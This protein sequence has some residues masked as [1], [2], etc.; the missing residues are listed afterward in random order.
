M[1]SLLANLFSWSLSTSAMASILA[2]FIFVAKWLLKDRINPRWTY[3]LWM[4]L[5][6]RLLLPWTPE[7][8]F[9]VFNIIHLEKHQSFKASNQTVLGNE[10]TSAPNIDQYTEMTTSTLPP[11]IVVHTIGSSPTRDKP[12][13]LMLIASG[14]W[15][16]GAVLMLSFIIVANLRFNFKIRKEQII[17]DK[18]VRSILNECLVKMKIHRHVAL[19]ESSHVSC[20]TLVGLITPKLLLPR[21]TIT[22]LNVSQLR[23][24]FLHELSHIKRY[25]I[26]MNWMMNILL[27]LHWFNP[28]IL[29]AYHKMREDQEMACDSLALTHIHPSE[30]KDYAL[31]IIKLLEAYSSPIRLANAA[32]FSGNKDELKRRI[33]MITSFKR[34][35]KWSLIGPI[36]VL[37]LGICS[38]TSAKTNTIPNENNLSEPVFT[39][40]HL[41]ENVTQNGQA[42]TGHPIENVKPFAGINKG[43]NKA[44]LVVE[45]DYLSQIKKMNNKGEYMNEVAIILN[46][47]AMSHQKIKADRMGFSIKMTPEFLDLIIENIEKAPYIEDRDNY[48][49]I[50]KNWKAGNFSRV[51]DDHDYLN[52]RQGGTIGFST[53][54]NSA[55]EEAAF[56]KEWFSKKNATSGPD[57]TRSVGSAAP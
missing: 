22:N 49:V 21:S 36:V 37:L 34:S 18:S 27:T 25:D 54:V 43:P 14:I 30:S 51:R 15:L 13:S 56:V 6:L 38:L 28:I 1:T 3:F 48:L 50:A 4:I 23:Y 26:A 11:Q 17:N 40:S 19:I 39:E 46:L 35:Y 5:A 33:I 7:S 42:K 31:T 47:H 12:I 29:Y 52:T 57:D 9:S 53:G 44:L 32:N 8:S 20:P 55:Q 24:V 2:L 10:S 16:I 45:E 41:I